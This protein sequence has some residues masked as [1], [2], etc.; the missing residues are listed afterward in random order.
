MHGVKK[1]D[2]GNKQVR[3]FFHDNDVVVKRVYEIVYVESA[4]LFLL[5]F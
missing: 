3:F 2:I 1:V 5:V 4:F